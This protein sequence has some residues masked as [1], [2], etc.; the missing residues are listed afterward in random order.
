MAAV[1]DAKAPGETVG[2]LWRVE[3]VESVSTTATGITV[4]SA[5]RQDDGVLFVL[6]GGTAAQTGTITA[7]VVKPDGIT[8]IET[9]YVPVIDSPAQTA[10]T[11]R[12]YINFALRPIVGFGESADAEE[13]ADGL[14]KLSALI[15]EMRACGADIGAPYPLT[16]DS[17][18]YCPDWSVSGLR[19]GLRVQ[20]MP[21]FGSEPTAMDYERARRGMQL[22]KQKGLP[23]VRENE[24]F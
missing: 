12:E 3:G 20:V 10:D 17:V 16:A 18:I 15:A 7:T 2:R 6:S 9:F 23:E 13:F 21:D 19:Y 14:E 24:F 4:V 5:T 8:L 22:A 1:L 11:A